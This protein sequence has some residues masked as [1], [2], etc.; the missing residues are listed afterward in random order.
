MYAFSIIPYVVVLDRTTDIWTMVC[1]VYI[2]T[3]TELT[4]IKIFV[5]INS[6]NIF[7]PYAIDWLCFAGTGWWLWTTTS[8]HLWTPDW[9]AGPWSWSPIPRTHVSPSPA[10][11][12]WVASFIPLTS[13][14]WHSQDLLSRWILVM[15]G[16]HSFPNSFLP[17]TLSPYYNDKNK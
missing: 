12:H 14:Q 7:W 2:H 9:S 8:S 10:E 4:G 13:G 3:H 5:G 11:S 15:M 6:K 16:S 1:S 17:W